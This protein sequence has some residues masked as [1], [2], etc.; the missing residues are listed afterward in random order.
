[1]IPAA[2][3]DPAREAL[4]RCS[5]ERGM[6]VTA[7]RLAIYRELLSACDHPR[8]E[9]LFRRVRATTPSLSLATVYKA[10]DALV[11]LGLVRQVPVAGD[12]KRFDANLGRHHHLVCRRCRGVTDIVDRKL[13]QIALTR[14][15]RGFLVQEV[16][17]ELLGLCSSCAS[18][19]VARN[20]SR[21]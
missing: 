17:V 9:E 3:P 21:N 2:R 19:P 13:D 16:R 11:D 4:L 5:R 8:P 18:G 14:R 1:M 6:R 7:Q 12:V 10:L 20:P 15:P